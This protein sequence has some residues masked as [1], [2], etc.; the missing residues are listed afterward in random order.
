M[1]FEGGLL[2]CVLVVIVLSAPLEKDHHTAAVPD[3]TDLEAWCREHEEH[4]AGGEVHCAVFLPSGVLAA[5]RSPNAEERYWCANAAAAAPAPLVLSVPPVELTPSARW[6]C[7]R[8]VSGAVLSGWDAL[9]VRPSASL[10][11][12]REGRRV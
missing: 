11:I 5:A 6:R 10:Q 8:H 2:A 7:A 1:H 3:G 4:E 12:P 9:V